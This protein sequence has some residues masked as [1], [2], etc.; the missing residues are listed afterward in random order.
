MNKG[1]QAVL[2]GLAVV[3][4]FGTGCNYLKSRDHLNKGVQAF[5]SAKYTQAVD[6]FKEAVQL[7]PNNP[8]AR[9]YL[10]TAYMSQYI[11]G[12]RIAGK[13][14]ERP[15]RRTGVSEGTGAVAKGYGC[16]QFSCLLAL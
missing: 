12:R 11:P 7:D 14:T 6:H 5:K 13:S 3:A 8:N 4:M 1:N 9:L 2:A 15:G 16:D 10:A